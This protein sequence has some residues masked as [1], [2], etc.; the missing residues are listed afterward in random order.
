MRNVLRKG[1]VLNLPYFSVNTYFIVFTHPYSIHC[2]LF[3]SDAL[4]YKILP[5]NFA[6]VQHEKLFCTHTMQSAIMELSW[7]I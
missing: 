7:L 6:H 5:S 3:C 2:K 4:A 1:T